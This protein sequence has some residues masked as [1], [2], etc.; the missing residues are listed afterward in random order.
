MVMKLADEAA[1]C[2]GIAPQPMAGRMDMTWS[3]LQP[4]LEIAHNFLLWT[5]H[6]QPN[7]CIAGPTTE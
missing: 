1:Y 7:Q 4:H 3:E 6:W 2:E 5:F